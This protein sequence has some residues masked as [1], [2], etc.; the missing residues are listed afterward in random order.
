M[1]TYLR[2]AVLEKSPWKP[3]EAAPK[4]TL[5]RLTLLLLCSLWI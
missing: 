4:L 5:L 2:K 1:S 3:Q